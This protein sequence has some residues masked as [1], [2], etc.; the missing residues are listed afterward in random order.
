[1][2]KVD[3]LMHSAVVRHP[4]DK[5][6]LN[7][8][9]NRY[10]ICSGTIDNLITANLNGHQ[11]IPGE[12]VWTRTEDNRN[13]L[14]AQDCWRSGNVFI[15]EFDKGVKYKTLQEVYDND[16]FIRN[17][18][19]AI[20]TSVRSGYDDP[21]DET[22]NGELRYRVWF[23]MRYVGGTGKNEY[24]D[25]R[26]RRSQWEFVKDQLLSHFQGKCDPQGSELILG[27]YGIKGAQSLFINNPI[28]DNFNTYLRSNFSKWQDEQL[29]RVTDPAKVEAI[30]TMPSHIRK[31]IPT[32]RFREN[33]WSTGYMKCIFNDHEDDDNNPKMGIAKNENGYTVHCFKCGE[34]RTF[35][36]SLSRRDKIYKI[37][38]G[39]MRHLSISRPKQKLIVSKPEMIYSSLDDNRLRIREFINSDNK[40]L[41]ISTETGAGKTQIAI[42]HAMDMPVCLTVPTMKL[43]KD[44]E[45]KRLAEHDYH[46]WKSRDYLYEDDEADMEIDV[47]KLPYG[48]FF[49]QTDK[50][51]ISPNQ[52]RDYGNKGG[53]VVRTICLNCPVY[54]D[55]REAGYISQHRHF[56]DRQLQIICMPRIFTDPHSA[57]FAKNVIG[58]TKRVGIIDEAKAHAFYNNES[59]SRMMIEKLSEIWK[60]KDLGNLCGRLLE[61]WDKPS[62]WHNIINCS[63]DEYK[64]IVHELGSVRCFIKGVKETFDT[65]TRFGYFA[66]LELK[67]IFPDCISKPAVAF[68][69]DDED[70]FDDLIEQG[71]P[72]LF[73]A[74]V[75]VKG[76]SAELRLT[77]DQLVKCNILS[78]DKIY[79]LPKVEGSVNWY[80]EMHRSVE[81][82]GKILELESHSEQFIQYHTP[83]VVHEKLEKLIA[84]SATLD[85]T[86]FNK[87]F[88]GY[89]KQYLKTHHTPFHKD[90]ELV[91]VRTGTYPVG[92]WAAD[93]QLTQAALSKLQ[94]IEDK[95]ESD[96][97]EKYAIISSQE[98]IKL[99]KDVWDDM[100][101]YI[102]YTHFG[103]TEGLDE[104][105]KDVTTVIILGS[106]QLPPQT[107]KDTTQVLFGDET[108]PLN[109][110]RNEGA[111]GVNT[112]VDH[113]VQSVHTQAVLG[114]LI[115][116]IGRGRLNLYGK[117]V[118]IISCYYIP[119]FSERAYL[120]DMADIEVAER[121]GTLVDVIKSRQAE[122]NNQTDA[123]KRALQLLRQDISVR[124]ISEVTKLSNYKI[125]KLRKEYDIQPNREDY[126]KIYDFIRLRGKAKLG[127]ILK[128]CGF[129]R[130]RTTYLL[131]KMVK[132]KHILKSGHGTYQFRER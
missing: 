125:G 63:E 88:S 29:K 121:F 28:S 23:A 111:N 4:S 49:E 35:K 103:A 42:D 61:N 12:F 3:Y 59:I 122:E 76:V 55:C 66:T 131:K 21:N 81:H 56:K 90:A 64:N 68:L 6:H 37:R 118:I 126:Y 119:N 87:V 132:F 38:Q 50:V 110:K 39:V 52:C 104:L 57:G 89:S 62:I 123:E 72:V 54:E 25:I 45:S 51:C 84:M 65:D 85:Q 60:G 9:H 48:N 75:A 20:T 22:C 130:S 15:I 18:A 96:P 16:E 127:D 14:R 116:C 11:V 24:D 73:V 2:V 1:M 10:Q 26:Y 31:A 114:E 115:Q 117:R 30:H 43:A 86:H 17:N 91:Q 109:F 70:A 92:H 99:R 97:D 40:V 8:S 46:I 34:K 100:E 113:R 94:I 27:A 82:Y 83:P 124:R 80:T 5:K 58:S 95:M 67:G 77:L 47:N 74:N 108:K 53:N 102:V 105:F 41:G 71:E 112:Y 19:Y 78:L 13:I 107:I 106:F 101:A 7:H 128:A 79:E 33:G 36:K 44:I 98:V 93:G 129:S 32:M 120:A 69:V